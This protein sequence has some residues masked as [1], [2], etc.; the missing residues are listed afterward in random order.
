MFL[1]LI[2]IG[3]DMTNDKKDMIIGWPLVVCVSIL[4]LFNYYLSFL[5]TKQVIEKQCKKFKK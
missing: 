5:G 1:L 4:I 2:F 3:K